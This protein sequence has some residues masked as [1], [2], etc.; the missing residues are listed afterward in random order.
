M[1]HD[2]FISHSS[3]DKTTADAICGSLETNGIRCWIAPRDITPGATW[4]E[5][6][7]SALSRCTVMVV[8]LS[9]GSNDSP[10]VLREVERAIS[11]GLVV[12]P[13]RIEDVSPSGA[14]EYFL[15]APHWL[16]ALTPP[17]E[18][19]L[20]QLL[21]TIT[22]LLRPPEEAAPETKE[23][24]PRK[25]QSS[26]EGK[27]ALSHRTRVIL[28]NTSSAF[29]HPLSGTVEVEIDGRYL[30]RLRRK[31]YIEAELEAGEHRLSLRHLDGKY[32]ENTEGFTVD[33]EELYMKVFAKAKSTGFEM[34]A[35]LPA[36]FMRK[37]R[38]AAPE[39]SHAQP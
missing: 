19:H 35:E 4:G 9:S 27:P 16:D 10:Q 6:I 2:V 31:E 21:H 13:F 38:R 5:E 14:L 30:G 34:V 7:I 1:A 33:G 12:V 18:K 8:V 28:F 32:W 11:K 36:F 17:L 15:S 39:D 25:E 3:R 20:R 23:P 37:F 24:D 26:Q 22:L 29:T